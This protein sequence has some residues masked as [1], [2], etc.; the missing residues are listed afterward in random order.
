MESGNLP[1]VGRM[2]TQE[3]GRVIGK[4][5]ETI[6]RWVHLYD[7]R[8]K[9][10]GDEMWIDVEDLWAAVPYQQPSQTPRK[11]RGGARKKAN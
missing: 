9:Q 1:L 6:R 8:F 2:T 5:A 3:L 4:S 11:P 10:F 7:V